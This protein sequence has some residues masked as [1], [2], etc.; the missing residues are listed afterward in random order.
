MHN[1]DDPADSPIIRPVLYTN[2]V[3][4]LISGFLGALFT[5]AEPERVR[6]ALQAVLDNWDDHIARFGQLKRMVER[7]TGERAERGTGH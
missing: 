6:V 4:R 7:S 3:R 1:E 2:D 5:I